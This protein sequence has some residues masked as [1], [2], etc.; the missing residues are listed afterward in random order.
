MPD[1]RIAVHHD[2]PDWR[3]RLESARTEWRGSIEPADASTA[4][5]AEAERVVIL[6]PTRSLTVEE[7][8]ATWSHRLR[9]LERSG[10]PLRVVDLESDP[11]WFRGLVVE[12]PTSVDAVW[13]PAVGAMLGED[14]EASIQKLTHANCFSRVVPY[15]IA[16]A[17]C[18]GLVRPRGLLGL[19][20]R[21]GA[22]V[23]RVVARHGRLDVART[24]ASRVDATVV[25]EWLL[26]GS[27]TSLEAPPGDRMEGRRFTPPPP[28]L[29]GW[30]ADE[31]CAIGGAL[32][33]RAPGTF[34][35]V[36]PPW[37]ARWF[38]LGSVTKIGKVAASGALLISLAVGA[39]ARVRAHD[40]DARGAA[41]RRDLERLRWEQASLERTV[42]E[43]WSAP[44]GASR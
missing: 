11:I 1:V 25:K 8:H 14:S 31:W 37:P 42:P 33:A 26:V 44:N 17:S 29:E 27:T 30:S 4:D 41:L 15:E 16:V 13:K 9:R 39:H 22:R 2:Q 32:G 35:T 24:L 23:D 20:F 43:E 7:P 21:N 3:L 34:P 19:E 5:P 12:V 38:R 40:A 36:P 10:R 18:A 6:E 28:Q